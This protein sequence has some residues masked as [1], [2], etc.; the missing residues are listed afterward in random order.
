VQRL[1]RFPS[2]DLATG[3]KFQD[4]TQLRHADA[5]Y[6]FTHLTGDVVDVQVGGSFREYKLNSFGTVFTDADGPIKYSEFGVYTQVQ[7]K[8]AD[9]RIKVTGSVRYD[10]SQLFDGN[11][12]PR[13]SVSYTLGANRNR[14]LRASVQTGFRNPT[15]QDLFIG[16][17]IGQTTLLGSA[18]ENL[19]RF[20]ERDDLNNVYTGRDAYEN[21]YSA[22][23][24]ANGTFVQADI[25]IVKPE[26]ITAYEVGYRA[27]F[28]SVILDGSIYYN[29]YQDF[30]ANETVIAPG[31]GSVNGTA[32][33]QQ[34]ARDAAVNI[35]SRKIFT[36]STNSDVDIS[37]YGLIGGVSGQFKGFDLG[38]NYTFADFDFDQEE[39]PDFRSSFNTPKH[40]VKASIGKDDLFTNFGF[41]VNAVWSDEYFW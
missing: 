32:A 17:D 19:D 36:A 29:Q 33:E 35:Q 16:L 11:F 39:D 23:S 31:V 18:E 4:N 22:Q 27:Q 40:K 41:G 13:L 5:N 28:G 21:S 8:F 26:K 14:N 34:A 9:E 15:T 37:S 6:N 7:K 10:K 3:S 24:V 38:V 12:S 1:F 20:S 30:I 2:P 25:D